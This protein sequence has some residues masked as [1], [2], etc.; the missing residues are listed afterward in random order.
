MARVALGKYGEYP[1]RSTAARRAREAGRKGRA[2]APPRMTVVEVRI[3]AGNPAE[4]VA[5]GLPFRF[6]V[7]HR[8]YPWVPY[9]CRPILATGWAQ[10]SLG[11]VVPSAPAA[12]RSTRT[13][14]RPHLRSR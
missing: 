1:N 14:F 2:G 6:E 9:P 8:S 13:R 7:M 4:P 12:A 3:V 11:A 5:G 10:S